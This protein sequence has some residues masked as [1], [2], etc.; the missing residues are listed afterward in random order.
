MTDQDFPRCGQDQLFGKALEDRR[1]EL[2]FQRQDLAADRRGGDVEM[3]CRLADRACAGNLI[4][5]VQQAA[6]QHLSALEMVH[7]QDGFALPKR[8]QVCRNKAL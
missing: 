3:V 1:S 7:E 5:V 8:Q 2:G 4:D 6:V